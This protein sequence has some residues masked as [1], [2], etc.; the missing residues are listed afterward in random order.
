MCLF[1][2]LS[3]LHECQVSKISGALERSSKWHRALGCVIIFG[4]IAMELLSKFG[5]SNL[6][7][8]NLQK[9]FEI[10]KISEFELE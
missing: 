7:A 1:Y 8:T 10:H 4:N 9:L 3:W 6:V 2:G 5:C